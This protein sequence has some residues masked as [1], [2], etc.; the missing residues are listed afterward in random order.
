MPKIP[1]SLAFLY[2]TVYHLKPRG[3]PKRKRRP[4]GS[5]FVT[6]ASENL[7]FVEGLQTLSTHTESARL[8]VH[9]HRALGNV[10]A[11]LTVG[12]PF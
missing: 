1:A 12:A 6:I 2:P 4:V 10:G 8:A 9:Y 5:A 7:G 3:E 11:E